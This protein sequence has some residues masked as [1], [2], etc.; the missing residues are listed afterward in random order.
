MTGAIRAG[1]GLP[2]TPGSPDQNSVPA[3]I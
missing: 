2:G 1:F 3:M